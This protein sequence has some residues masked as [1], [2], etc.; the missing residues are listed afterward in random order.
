MAKEKAATAED[1]NALAERRRQ[2]QSAE[3]QKRERE[4]AQRG[5]LWSRRDFFGRLSWGGFG[6]VSLMG[7][8]AFV[9]SAFPRVLFVPPSTFKAGLPADY[10]VGEVSEKYKTE[11]RVW[12]IR[13]PLGFY[14]I[15]AKCTHLGCTPR[16]LASENKYKCPCHGSGYYKTGYNFEGPAPRPMDRV[17]IALGEDGQLVV[18]KSVLF[19]MQ[20]GVDPNKQ[21][22]ESILKV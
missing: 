22:P 15:F 5:G 19:R 9:R 8:L 7:L 4:K 11:F 18:D 21:H 10:P 14:A 3:R 1:L 20:P 12:I 17:K 16:W 6:V 13:E 2:E